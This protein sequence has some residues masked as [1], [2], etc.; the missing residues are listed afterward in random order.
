LPSGSKI[1]GD[2]VGHIVGDRHDIVLRD[3]Q[4]LA[5][6]A[7]AVDTDAERVAAEMPP[8]RAQL[9]QWPQTI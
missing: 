8:A 4:I 7:G 3:R 1:A 2:L 6:G 9:R 5:E